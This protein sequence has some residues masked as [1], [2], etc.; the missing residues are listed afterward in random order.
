MRSAAVHAK[1]NRIS[2]PEASPG[3]RGAAVTRGR[4]SSVASELERQARTLR[5][6]ADQLETLGQQGRSSRAVLRQLLAQPGRQE[7]KGALEPADLLQAVAR[8]PRADA[9]ALRELPGRLKGATR[10]V[11]LSAEILVHHLDTM[12]TLLDKAQ[13]GGAEGHH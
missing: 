10:R 9:E 13:G 3:P 1:D 12:S 8:L 7:S 5:R 11:R 4:G 2:R 6:L